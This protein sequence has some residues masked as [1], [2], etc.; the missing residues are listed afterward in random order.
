QNPKTTYGAVQP[1]IGG[2]MSLAAVLRFTICMSPCPWNCSWT[3]GCRPLSRAAPVR[4]VAGVSLFR[5]P[6]DAVFHRAMNRN[7]RQ[8]AM[9]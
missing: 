5:R 2:S 3:T 1:Q 6:C 4:T 8:H 7:S 9:C